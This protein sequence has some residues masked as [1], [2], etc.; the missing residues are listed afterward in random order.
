MTHALSARIYEG[1]DDL[2]QFAADW[3][4]VLRSCRA[5]I[6]GPDATCS[7]TKALSGTLPDNRAITT[8]VVSS[9]SDVV[10]IVP[11]YSVTI[12]SLALPRRE[13]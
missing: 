6:E 3:D 9:G 10:A 12:P 4:R 7:M 5:G 11:T 13:L 8:L 2:E 1:W